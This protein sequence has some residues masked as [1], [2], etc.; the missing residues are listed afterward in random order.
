VAEPDQPV[1]ELPSE[2]DVEVEVVEIEL[3]PNPILEFEHPVVSEE[4][5]PDE[6]VLDWPE[7]N[8]AAVAPLP[9]EE[10]AVVLP[11]IMPVV[12]PVDQPKAEET[13]A[14]QMQ[15]APIAVAA[16]TLPVPA[17]APV[18]SI[19]YG[20]NPPVPKFPLRPPRSGTKS[21]AVTEPEKGKP[22]ATPPISPLFAGRNSQ[23][24]FRL[25]QNQTAKTPPMFGANPLDRYFSTKLPPPANWEAAGTL[26]G[27]TGPVTISRIAEAIS[28]LPEIA[29]CLLVTPPDVTIKGHWPE[30]LGA[31][32]SLAFARRLAGVLRRGVSGL[33]QRRI[34]TDCGVVLVFAMDDV[35]LCALSR[36]S[37]GSAGIRERL[38]VVTKAISYARKASTRPSEA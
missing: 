37:D 12:V 24:E 15:P 33:S 25:Q 23:T 20:P 9:V 16:P 35:L 21:D 4:L 6:T 19:R 29:G 36:S 17:P 38:S 34:M 28:N 2:V 1:L 31:C 26:L 22:K 5:I 14:E 30:S 10:A 32:N 8:V 7:A 27:V 18:I 11:A 13:T 3:E